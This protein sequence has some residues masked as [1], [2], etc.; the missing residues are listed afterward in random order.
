MRLFIAINFGG[1]TRARLTGLR[2]QLRSRS[3]GGNFSRTENLHLTLAFLG[4]CGQQR[5]DVT[6]AAMSV[7]RFQPFDIIIERLGRCKGNGGDLWWI[8]LAA[9]ETLVALQGQLA[10]RLMAAGWTLEKGP[11]HPHI[12]L[13]R[14]VITG[15]TPWKIEPFGETVSTIDLMQSQRLD[16]GLRYTSIHSHTAK[17]HLVE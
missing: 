11:Y 8:G 10:A 9:C 12:T 16:G 14:R 6:K 17:Q 7:I 3:Q 1:E 15:A 5:A 2:D 13:G 4:E